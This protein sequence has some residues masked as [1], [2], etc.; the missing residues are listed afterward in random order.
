MTPDETVDLLSLIAARDRRTVGRTDVMAWHADIGDLDFTDASAAVSLHFR[1]SDAWIMPKH[2]RDLVKKIRGERLEGFR[3][4]PVPGDDDPQVYLKNLREQRAAVASG[5]REA[6]PAITTGTD[7][8]ADVQALL[9]GVFH[10]APKE[11]KK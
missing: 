5:Q 1:Q 3:Y 10:R 9:A 11:P 4:I 6:D 2:V 7:R 8:S